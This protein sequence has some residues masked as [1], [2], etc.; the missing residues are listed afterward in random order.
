MDNPS[1]INKYNKVRNNVRQ[2][3]QLKYFKKVTKQFCTLFN[4]TF[5]DKFVFTWFNLIKNLIIYI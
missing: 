3:G 2:K 4:I 1:K 5:I